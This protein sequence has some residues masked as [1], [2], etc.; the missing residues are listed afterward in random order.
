MEWLCGVE[1]VEMNQMMTYEKK[2][3]TFRSGRRDKR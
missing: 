3:G 1:G 2:F